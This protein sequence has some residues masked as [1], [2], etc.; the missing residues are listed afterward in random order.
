MANH[1][2]SIKRIRQTKV[3]K[4]RNR[5]YGR[6]MR[7]AIKKFRLIEDKQEAS[8]ELPGMYELIDKMVKKGLIHK[9]KGGNLKSSLTLQTNNL[10]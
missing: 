8:K 2:S 5:Y 10:S 3:R 6:T 9:N 7:N 4:L 1:K